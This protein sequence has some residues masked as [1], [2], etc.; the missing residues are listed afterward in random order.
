[1]LLYLPCVKSPKSVAFPAVAIVT[2][3]KLFFA[4]GESALPLENIPLVL[5]ESADA[6][7]VEKFKSQKSTATP[8]VVKER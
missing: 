7:A 1:M 8:P 2:K 6:N 5:D 4:P 3:S